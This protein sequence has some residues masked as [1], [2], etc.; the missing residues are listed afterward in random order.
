MALRNLLDRLPRSTQPIVLELDLARGVLEE[1]P[2]NP[3][4]LLQ[5]IGATSVTSLRENLQAAAKDPRVA[6]LIVHVAECGQPLQVLDEI[7]EVLEEFGRAKSTAAWSESFGELGNALGLFKLATACHRVFLQPTGTL[8]IGGLEVRITL[9]KGMLNKAGVDPQFGQRYEYKTAADQFSADEVTPANREMT[10]RVAQSIVDDVVATIA[11]RRGLEPQQVWDAV[12]SSPLT[13]VQA[14]ADGLVD[15]LAYRDQVYATLLKD[16]GA[17]PEQLLFV[18]RYQRR[19]QLTKKLCGAREKVAVV[20]LRGG[21]VTGRGGRSPFGGET[22]GA[23]LVDEHF[24]A[25]LRDEEF[26][27]VLFEVDSPG[28]SAVASDFIRRSVKRVQESGRPVVARMGQVAASGGYYVAM[29][30]DEIVALPTTLTGSIG[31]VAGKFVT[32]RLDDLLGLKREPIRIGAVAGMMSSAT[33][34]TEEDWERLNQELDRI[35]ENFTTFAAEDRGMVHE[36]LE[37][38]AKGRVWTGVDAKEHGL[39]DHLGGWNL[40]WQRACDLA[41]LDPE[42]TEPVRIGLGSAL[43]KLI[44]ARSSEHRAGSSRMLWPHSEQFWTGLASHVGLHVEGP[45]ALP[46]RFD[47]R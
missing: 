7:G 25:V 44:P 30:C 37:A 40:A 34:F 16:W 9:L 31:V 8:G 38:L 33:E 42:N 47:L 15:E 35:Y 28:G 39:V 10:T 24:R 23:D 45:L 4:Q 41:G 13:A 27:A 36:E 43:E 20:S 1:L 5:V 32:R 18:S 29:P 22:A 6:G 12:N 26:K 17:T 21:I 2:R 14:Q 19:G 3:L 11:E 46:W